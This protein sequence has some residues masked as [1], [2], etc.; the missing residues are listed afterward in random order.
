MQCTTSIS[1]RDAYSMT[2]IKMRKASSDSVTFRL[3]SSVLHKLS[4]RADL[5]KTS[6]NV[7]VNQVLCNYIEWDAD[8]IKAG[9]IPTQ[10]IVLTKLIDALDE[11]VISEIAE[12]SAKS[13]GKDSI[14]YMYGKYNLENL[15]KNIRA[16]S[17]RSGFSI[18]EYEENQ[19]MEIVIQ[20]DLGW[21][22][23]IFFKFYYQEILH[24]INQRVIF[25][26]TDTSLVINLVNE[27]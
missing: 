1:I 11:K 26:Y 9:W 24:E 8:S 3:N 20:H 18:K 23:S 5:Q 7:L 16:K 19:N 6:L 4:T 12:Q 15:L 22:W 17:Q 14:L 21:K 25:D 10:R 27:K 13:S 2:M